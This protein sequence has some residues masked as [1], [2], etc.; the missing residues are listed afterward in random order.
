MFGIFKT[1]INEKYSINVSSNSINKQ[2]TQKIGV[3]H[4]A[5]KYS[6]KLQV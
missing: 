3:L 1:K 4:A 5:L 6:L 2:I